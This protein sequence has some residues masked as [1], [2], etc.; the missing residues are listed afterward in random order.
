M[1]NA[2]VVFTLARELRCLHTFNI[3]DDTFLTWKDGIY[4]SQDLTFLYLVG[5]PYR[6]SRPM[7]L[8]P[9]PNVCGKHP[10][11][12][13]H[14]WLQSCVLRLWVVTSSWPC[15]CV[16]QHPRPSYK[17]GRFG[18]VSQ[19]VFGSRVDHTARFLAV[20]FPWLRHMRCPRQT[21]R[22]TIVWVHLFSNVH[23]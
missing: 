13:H 14:P 18:P 12:T 11:G 16:I 8:A 6:S 5:L 15:A 4:M 20:T 3:R 10:V 1:P 23:L 2:V 21:T 22:Y 9:H 19:S 17:R 7:R